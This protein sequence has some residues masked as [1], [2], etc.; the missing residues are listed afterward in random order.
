MAPLRLNRY[1]PT[2]RLLVSLPQVPAYL[3]QD[4]WSFHDLQQGTRE[5]RIDLERVESPDL[6]LSASSLTTRSLGLRNSSPDRF[7]VPWPVVG[8]NAVSQLP[9]AA[10][11]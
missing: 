9:N 2:I 1:T 3:V 5:Q 8:E 6:P 11:H 7:S 4:W 10:S